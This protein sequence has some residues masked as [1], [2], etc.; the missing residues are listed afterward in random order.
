MNI[1]YATLQN[2]IRRGLVQQEHIP[3]SVDSRASNE[4]VN[5]ERTTCVSLVIA[6]LPLRRRRRLRYFNGGH[7]GVGRPY[8]RYPRAGDAAVLGA[9]AGVFGI[10][11][12]CGAEA[13]RAPV[14]L[15]AY[16]PT[17]AA[18]PYGYYGGPRQYDR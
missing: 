7:A 9:V 4:G 13:L 6:P 11:A 16:G 5:S 2:I 18:A 15:M 12:A 14:R 1:R 3:I 8:D 17:A 10:I